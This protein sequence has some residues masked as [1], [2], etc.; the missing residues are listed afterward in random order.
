M[1]SQG[2]ICVAGYHFGLFN[3]SEKSLVFETG[4][5]DFLRK[6][7]INT[8]RLLVFEEG[9]KTF[10]VYQTLYQAKAGEQLLW[11]IIEA[12]NERWFL[13]YH[14]EKGHLQQQ[15]Q[16][17][18]Q[19]HTWTIRC[20]A[21][22]VQDAAVINPLAYPMAPLIWYVLTTEEPLLLI[23]ASGIADH[24][25]GRI[26]AGFSG[27]GKST[28]A[29][30]WERNGAQ[31]IN[32][33]RLLLKKEKDGSWYMHNTPMY[34][35]ALPASAPLNAIYLPFHNPQ[36]SYQKLNGAMAMANLLAFTIHHG[37][38]AKH[39]LHHSNI[40]EDLLQTVSIAKLGVV[41]TDAIVSYISAH[42]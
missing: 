1:R 5:E 28:M 35:R 21:S 36:N 39:L 37:Y 23:H 32:D 2:S 19:N 29:G 26:F 6:D 30:I 9:F 31:V 34:Y 41:P 17:N 38:D 13:V 20:M 8:D 16:Y 15:A 25:A 24:G 40:A 18:P 10:S 3:Q 11:E 12:N 33:D 4:F 7:H 27:V 14:P 42:E 22:M